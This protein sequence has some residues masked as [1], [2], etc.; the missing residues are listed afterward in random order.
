MLLN[1]VTIKDWYLIILWSVY[2]NIISKLEYYP[3]LGRREKIDLIFYF[4]LCGA[5]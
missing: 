4:H 1:K 2:T 5:F 3:D